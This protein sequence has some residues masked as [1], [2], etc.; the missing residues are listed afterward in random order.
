LDYPAV[1]RPHEK[2]ISFL[3][4]RPDITNH[5]IPLSELKIFLSKDLAEK[6][7]DLDTGD[8]IVF[9]GKVFSTALGDPWVDVDA[10][11]VVNKINKDNNKK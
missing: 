6:N 4:Q 11:K 7:I 9:T 1:N 5:N 2:Y 3:I 10:I 8:E